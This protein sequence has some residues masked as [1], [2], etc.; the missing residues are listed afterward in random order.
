MIEVDHWTT[1]DYQYR[2][3]NLLCPFILRTNR[4]IYHE[5]I[6]IL[7]SKNVFS[8][9]LEKHHVPPHFPEKLKIFFEKIGTD[10][11]AQV[12]EICI[13]HSNS[14]YRSIPIDFSETEDFLNLQD[15]PV[16]VATAG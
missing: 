14:G 8:L 9:R 11:A 7:Y 10:N 3:R 13:Y 1:Q 5:S 12:R 15:H 4:Q 16:P 2:E 6:N